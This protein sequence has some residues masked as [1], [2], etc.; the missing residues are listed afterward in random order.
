MTG[1]RGVLSALL[2]ALLLLALIGSFALIVHEAEHD[3]SGEGC[4]VCAMIAI[5]RDTLRRFTGA[6]VLGAA[7]VWLISFFALGVC[8]SARERCVKTPV[9]LKVKLLN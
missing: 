1:K 7:V 9:F 8:I 2:A 5:C 6:V 3:C 4:P